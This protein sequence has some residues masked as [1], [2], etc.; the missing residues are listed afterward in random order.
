LPQTRVNDA[1]ICKSK[2][3]FGVTISPPNEQRA[4]AVAQ[5]SAAQLRGGVLNHDPHSADRVALVHGGAVWTRGHLFKAV[6]QLTRGFVALGIRTGD[7]VVLHMAN[8]PEFVVAYLAC[9]QS[10]AIAVPINPRLKLSE[11]KSILERIE[12]ALYIGQ[13]DLYNKVDRLPC[14]ALGRDAR[15]LVDTISP[16]DSGRTWLDLLSDDRAPDATP[17]LK[18]THPS[19]LLSTSGTSGLPK[20]GVHTRG[21]LGEILQRMASSRSDK[22]TFTICATPIAHAMS[23]LTL[24]STIHYGEA[25]NLLNGFE[26]AAVL[27]EIERGRG[28][29]IM[30]LP[31]M[32][33]ALADEQEA[34]PKNVEAL[35]NCVSGGD[36]LSPRLQKKFEKAFGVKL[37]NIYSATEAS[38]SFT[39][40]TM[41]FR[42]RPGVEVKLL[43]RAGREMPEGV[44]SIRGPNVVI[45]YWE[46]P[47]SI[48][49]LGEG[50][51]FD[52][53]D[54]VREVSPGEL[55][56][57]SRF[58]D[59]IIRGGSNIAPMEVEQALLNHELVRDAAVIGIPDERLGERVAGFIQVVKG[60]PKPDLRA[61]ITDLSVVIADYKLP[62]M[63]KVVDDL[64]RNAI[65]KI[66]RAALRSREP[67]DWD[68][69]FRP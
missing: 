35:Q 55:M 67:T 20:L 36:N 12:P 69:D 6:E 41:T 51:W 34:H 52:T 19:L 11:I 9:F 43:D 32:F 56:Y 54:I 22:S 13:D 48:V 23:C 24:L 50:G 4:A 27:H 53:G 28:H 44:M 58:K 3:R 57:V 63:L 47:S 49:P 37:L 17:I 31:H 59:I 61:L 1:S 14:S 18:A 15:V 8:C 25:V 68:L 40:G 2:V 10:G 5:T 33:N 66:D 46:S 16:I 45:G 30:L 26:P 65:G 42:S 60:A 62:E 38:A 39:P 64:P 7:R 29:R 21:T